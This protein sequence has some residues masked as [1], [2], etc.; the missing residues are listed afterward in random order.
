MFASKKNNAS[1]WHEVARY[2]SMTILVGLLIGIYTPA[3]SQNDASYVREVARLLN[4]QTE[5]RMYGGRADVVTEEYAIEVEYAHLWK[6]SI[7][8]SLWYGIQLNK[9]AGIVLIMRTPDDYKYGI[10]LQSTLDHAGL[11]DKIRV[12]FY[13]EDFG[14]KLTYDPKDTAPP[15]LHQTDA[16]CL[17]WLNTSTNTRHN[18]KCSNFANTKNGRCATNT[19]G[20]ACGLCK[21]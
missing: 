15:P 12:W 14:G 9:K 7:G 10:M 19:E 6:Q 4:G 11:N 13:P 2:I 8:Q 3:E 18:Q 21:G 20:K 1:L 17:F 16:D 5:V